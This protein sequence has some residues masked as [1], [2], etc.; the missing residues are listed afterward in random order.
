MKQA[1]I[2]LLT[3]GLLM[4]SFIAFYSINCLFMVVSNYEA[5]DIVSLAGIPMLLIFINLVIA[6]VVGYRYFMKKEPD[7]YYVRYY[8]IVLSVM[9]VIGLG[10]SAFVGACIYHTFVGDYIFKCY[11]LISIIVFSLMIIGCVYLIVIITNKVKAENI[12]KTYKGTFAYGLREAGLSILFVYALNRLGAFMLIPYYWSSYDSAYVLP[13][14]FQLLVPTLILATYIIH[15]DFLRN[16]KVTFIL[17]T[18]AFT[19][20]LATLIYMICISRDNY[21]LI[22][23]PLS[24][25]Q[26]FERLVKFPVDAIMMYGIS[27]IIPF[28]NALNNGILLVKEK[29]ANKVE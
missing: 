23:N 27:L 15:E 3:L 26:Q 17:S 19:F 5:L 4:L 25:I 21:P 20:S 29:K 2:A 16:R 9:S 28:L 1:K 6:F 7:I 14:L 13:Y 18:I 8:A 11:P 12:E 22:L 10:M 24:A